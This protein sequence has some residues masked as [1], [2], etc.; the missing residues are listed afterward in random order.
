MYV[1]LLICT[2][3]DKKKRKEEKKVNHTTVHFN[4]YHSSSVQCSDKTCL[5]PFLFAIHVCIKYINK[6]I[7][8]MDVTNDLHPFLNPD[9]QT[10]EINKRLRSEGEN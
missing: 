4:F 2:A 5:I 1:V 7:F 10:P 3:W 8:N 6:Y 9:L